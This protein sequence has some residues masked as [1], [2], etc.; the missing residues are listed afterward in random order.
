LPQQSSFIELLTV[1]G[2]EQAYPVDVKT[3]TA[4]AV[5]NVNDSLAS[6]VELDVK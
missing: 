4:H 2:Q 3:A 6:V 5:V 1:N